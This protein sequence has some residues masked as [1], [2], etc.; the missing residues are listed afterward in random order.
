MGTIDWIIDHLIKFNVK[1]TA[2]LQ[3]LGT[4]KFQPFN[5]VLGLSSDQP[6][7]WCALG[8]ILSHFIS[9]IKKLSPLRKSPGILTLQA[10]NLGQRPD[11][12]LTIP[13]PP[14]LHSHQQE[15][16]R[17]QEIPLRT[18]SENCT[19]YFGLHSTGQNV[20]FGHSDYEKGWETWFSF[21]AIMCLKTRGLTITR[22]RDDGHWG[23]VSSL[24]HIYFFGNLWSLHIFLDVLF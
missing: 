5:H 3:R 23:A 24:S 21:W 2:P 7:S 13:S 1:P 9:I 4:C 16:E 12:L 8:S 15:G 17:C 14:C 20:N 10:R 11:K 22:K 6:L 19:Y 18:W